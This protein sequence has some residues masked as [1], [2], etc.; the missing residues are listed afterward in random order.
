MCKYPGC[1]RPVQAKE[2]CKN[3]YVCWVRRGR[4]ESYT[5]KREYPNRLSSK[6]CTICNEPHWAKGY[7]QKHHANYL[8]TGSPTGILVPCKYPGCEI[9]THDKYCYVHQHTVKIERKKKRLGVES[10]AP[11]GWAMKGKL[12][13]NW[14]NGKYM[15]PNHY[16]M[17]LMR[18]KK[19]QETNGMCEKCGQPGLNMHHMDL[20]KSNHDYSNFIFLCRKCHIAEHIKMGTKFG[21][22]KGVKNK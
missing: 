14:K 10:N 7:C 21:R 22:R 8:R 11:K 5:V 13:P 4:P 9:R 12:N 2:Y 20:S 18:K 1:D 3:H 19:I 15:Y 16:R 6:K 17:K